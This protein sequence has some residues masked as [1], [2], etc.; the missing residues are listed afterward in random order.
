MKEVPMLAFD[1]L[2]YANKLKAA[3]VPESQAEVQ[4][5]AMAEIATAASRDESLAK[6]VASK[7]DLANVR[8]ELKE[9]IASVK[10]ELKEDIAALDMKIASVRSDLKE[11]IASV[12]EGMVRMEAR[13]EN[14]MSKLEVRLITWFVVTSLTTMGI[15]LAFLKFFF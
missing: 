15:M 6:W 1:T 13:L 10:L 5:Q 7:E 14:K 8:T 12:R 11:D 3:G 4:A 2:Q 9:D